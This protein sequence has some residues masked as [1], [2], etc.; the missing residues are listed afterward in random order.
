MDKRD[1]DH[2]VCGSNGSGSLRVHG[3]TGSKG[4]G[5][6]CVHGEIGS[7]GSGLQWESLC[8]HGQRA[9]E[10]SGLQVESMC[11]HGS[12]GDMALDCL[13]LAECM[14]EELVLP[15]QRNEYGSVSVS[16]DVWAAKGRRKRSQSLPQGSEVLCTVFVNTMV[17][18]EQ[19]HQKLVESQPQCMLTIGALRRID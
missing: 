19:W 2:C 6:L 11:V 1:Q 13:A 7:K 14:P 8:V 5:S 9:P 17:D 4:S 12:K 3:A 15:D 16:H 10:G 18:A